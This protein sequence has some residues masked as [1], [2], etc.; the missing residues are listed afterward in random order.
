MTDELPERYF[1]LT[2][3]EPEDGSR[4]M[5]GP[6]SDH[7]TFEVAD[8]VSFQ[9]VYGHNMLLNFVLFAPDRGFPRHQHPEEQLGMV[10]EGEMEF[11]IGDETR[12]IRA[13]DVYVIPSEVPHE[14]RTHE[15]ACLMLD[16]FAPP[17]SGFRELLERSMSRP[18]KLKWWEVG[19]E[20]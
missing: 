5:M 17:R 13:G 14:G 18:D 2:G 19:R 12:T 7:P 11:T 20:P 15:L 10:V 16:I 1:R 9:P 3:H 8:G 4:P 6:R